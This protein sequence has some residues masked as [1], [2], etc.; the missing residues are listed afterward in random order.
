MSEGSVPEGSP[1]TEDLDGT[2][3]R[4]QVVRTEV[5][6]KGRDM[7]FAEGKE[8]KDLYNQLLK[9]KKAVKTRF[10]LNSETVKASLV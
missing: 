7:V 10:T 3:E 6:L 8:S 9:K 1:S 4:G 2:V 5:L